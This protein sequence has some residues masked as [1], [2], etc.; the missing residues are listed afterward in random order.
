MLGKDHILFICPSLLE[1]GTKRGGGIEEIDFQLGKGFS[2]TSKVTI[3][4]PFFFESEKKQEFVENLAFKYVAF[5]AIRQ[6]PPRTK[7]N[8]YAS[9][10]LINPVYSALLGAELIS[11][12]LKENP[13]LVVLHNGLPG[14]I[15]SIICRL[16]KKRIIFSEG[17]LTPWTVPYLNPGKK[18]IPQ[19][20]IMKINTIAGKTIACLSDCI[21]VQSLSIKTGMVQAGIPEGKIT[22]IEG[23]VDIDTFFPETATDL[24]K[25]GINAAFIGRLAEEKGVL[26]LLDIVHEAQ[27]ELPELRFF[28]F[29]DGQYRYKFEG[30]SNIEH[31]GPVPKNELNAWLS[32]IDIV[33]FFQKDLGLA[34][35]ESLAAGKTILVCNAGEIPTIIHNNENGL[36]CEPTPQSYIDAIRLLVQHPSMIESISKNARTTAIERFSWDVIIKK[37]TELMERSERQKQW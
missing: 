17:N 20:Y 27:T 19:R 3:I 33:L 25:T 31:I 30:Y 8:Q 1:P 6:Y 37:W 34:V 28:I 14:L 29:G 16:A 21:R 36:L 5:P 7:F 35:L 32:Q 23:G 9:V 11:F 15:S 22:L 10:L 13:T 26:L 18:S 24:R 4:G 2:K 12:L